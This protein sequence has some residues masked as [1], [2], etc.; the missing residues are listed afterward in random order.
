[1]SDHSA[2]SP[3]AASSLLVE[4]FAARPAGLRA[5]VIADAAED[6]SIVGLGVNTRESREVF[7][8]VEDTTLA[9]IERG[10]G[11]IAL[12]ENPR[13]TAL[14]DRYITGHDDVDLDE[15][16]AQA[17]GPWQTV[18]MRQ[19]LIGLRGRNAGR[20]SPV[21][22]IGVGQARVLTQDYDRA[23]ELLDRIDPVTAA[24][25]TETL[26]VIR[27]AHTHGEHVLR[28]HGD[29]PGIP[30]ADLARTARSTVAELE[31]SAVRDEALGIL[32]GITDFHTHP[33][34]PGTD[35]SATSRE[36]AQRLLDHQRD[37]GERVVFWEGIAHVAAHPG[38]LLGSHLRRSLGEQYVAVLITFDH[39]RITLTDVPP[40]RP[41]SLE[42]TLAADDGTRVI[43][44][45]APKPVNTAAALDRTWSTR[46]ISGVYKAENDHDHY[47][48]LPSLSDSF[49]ALAYI[50]TI[51]PTRPLTD[52]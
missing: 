2:I 48:E 43:D 32:D 31:P 9:L 27:V 17:W 20:Q 28:A 26:D 50:P 37:T 25:V 35:M 38:A 29:H 51:T 18:E 10:F 6:A 46:L 16:L 4:W 49:D 11:T 8:F 21:R 36:A 7:G 23:V 3:S 5:D 15:A 42:A 47:T 19:A 12:L 41:D 34:A 1:M 22:I 13:V 24:D 30:F 40:P 33:T 45:H 39:G 14:Y 44:L 52:D